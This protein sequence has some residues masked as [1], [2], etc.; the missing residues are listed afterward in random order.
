MRLSDSKLNE[1]ISYSLRE[2]DREIEGSGRTVPLL[3]KKGEF[4]YKKD[5]YN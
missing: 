2:M 4:R 5:S 1:Y 3:P